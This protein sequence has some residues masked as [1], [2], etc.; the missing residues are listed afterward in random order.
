MPG[1]GRLD[2]RPCKTRWPESIFFVRK[3]KK[4]M[5]KDPK[6]IFISCA[7]EDVDEA[8]WIK[9]GLCAL[10]WSA[11][12]AKADLD[13]GGGSIAFRKAIDDVLDR[14]ICLVLVVTPSALSSAWVE[15]EWESIHLDMLN[16]LGGAIVPVWVS[17]DAQRRWPRPLRRFSPVDAVNQ[18]RE[19]VIES[20]NK[21]LQQNSKAGANMQ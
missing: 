4:F 5:K 8:L 16:G 12:V 3:V 17:G 7:D 13:D 14:A 11:Y 9:E 10:G 21:R 18:E 20:L 1:V 15:Y 6:T 19:A 2:A